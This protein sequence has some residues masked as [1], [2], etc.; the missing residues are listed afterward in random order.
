MQDSSSNNK[1]IA[2]NTLFLYFRMMIIMG[3]TLFT[4]RVVLQTLGVEDYGIY[5]VVGGIVVIFSFL[6][7][8]L[9]AASQR[10]ITFELGK[11]DNGNISNVFST[12]VIL[13]FFLALLIAIIA[14]PIGIWFINNKL[15]IPETRIPA[16]IWVFHFSIVSM[17]VMFISVPYNALIVAYERMD[18]FAIVSIIDALLRLGIAYALL[19]FKNIDKLVIYGILHL[20]AQIII[21]LCYTIFCTRMF[22]NVQFLKNIDKQ[23]LFEMGQFASWSILGNVAYMAYTQGLNLL[24]GT[25]FPPVVNAARGIAVQIQN[26]VNN[27]I[28]SFQTAINPQITKNYASDN[29]DE[30]VNLVFRSSR[31]SFYLI[32]ILSIPVILRTPDILRLWLVNVPDHSVTFVR[33][34]LVTSSI[35]AIANPLN[36]S[37]KATGKIRLYEITVGGLMIAILPVSYIFLRLGYAP[38]IVFIVHLCIECIAMLFRIWNTKTLIKFSYKSYFKEV[39]LRILVVLTLSLISSYI[40]SINFSSGLLQTIA[41]TLISVLISFLIIL[42]FGLNKTERTFIINKIK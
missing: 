40:V 22:T 20:I 31:F 9:S 29:I 12:C 19:M 8:S 24:L 5:N 33:I 23:L 28:N 7:S 15:M 42:L 32:M 25:F 16:A 17:F 35:H 14:E 34:I 18:A 36:I 1:R 2:K 27:F 6:N 11:G 38:E 3:V 37:V 30:M 10:F 39:I 21:R 41:V 4:S 26:A 13:H